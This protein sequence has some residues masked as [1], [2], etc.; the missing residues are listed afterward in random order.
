MRR[1]GATGRVSDLRSTD[2]GFKFYS[3]GG[4]KAA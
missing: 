4:D 3:G 1:G 2:R